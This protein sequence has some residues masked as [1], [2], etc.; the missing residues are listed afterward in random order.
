EA[1]TVALATRTE[2][3]A[4]GLQLAGLS[5]RG[6]V[7]PAGFVATF[8]GSHR[9]VLD[10][11]TEEVLEHQP[12]P[13]RGFLLETSVLEHLSGALCDAVTA[14]EMGW[15]A[16][17]IEQ[18]FD[19]LFYLRGEGATVQRWLSALPAD[20]IRSRPRL[21]VAQAALADASGRVDA[22]EGLLAAAERA[23]ADAA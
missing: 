17:L 21:L 8:S 5:L 16:R 18:H 22:V 11:L 12:E 4:A 6:Q 19:A 15:A 20:L 10:Y 1:A 7:D 23:S 3:W 9:Y 13:V 2:G 14:A